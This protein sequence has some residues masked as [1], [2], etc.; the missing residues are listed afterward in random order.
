MGFLT[1]R[2]KSAY[3]TQLA[4]AEEATRAFP[5]INYTADYKNNR[6]EPADTLKKAA[7]TAKTALEERTKFKDEL[8][9]TK[10]KLAES[11][12]QVQKLTTDYTATK[13][14]LDEKAEALTKAAADLQTAS[15]ELKDLKDKLGGRSIDDMI[16]DLNDAVEQA[17]VTSAEKKILDDA[18]A[19]VNSELE[20]YKE[21]EELARTKSAPLDLSGRVVAINKTWNFVVLDVGKDN[22]LAENIELTVYRGNQLIGKVRTVDVENKSA[23]ADVISDLTTGEI[24]VGDK[25][26]Y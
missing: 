18:L 7:G 5:N 1:A 8:D 15:T 21:L 6:K 17:K 19:K 2:T 9:G 12:S 10:T 3:S 11:D 20:K 14:D 24:Q 4:A 23:I 25:V 16:K 13:K 22:K 26:L